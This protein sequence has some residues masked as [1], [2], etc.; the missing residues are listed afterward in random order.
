MQD[1]GEVRKY[2][3]TTFEQ[4]VHD[5]EEKRQIES[6]ILKEQFGDDYA[7]SIDEDD[8]KKEAKVQASKSKE[9]RQDDLEA[10]NSENDPDNLQNVTNVSSSMLAGDD[11]EGDD[12][13]QPK[14]G[15]V[16][17]EN[18]KE[19]EEP[20][21]HIRPEKFTYDPFRKLGP[22]AFNPLLYVGTLLKRMAETRRLQAMNAR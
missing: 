8:E 22:Q 17:L 1:S 16:V 14:A 11:Y 15:E 18:I 5:H 6:R 12:D 7:D 9:F 19:E 21:D 13:N 20:D 3:E 2:I 10:G 4:R